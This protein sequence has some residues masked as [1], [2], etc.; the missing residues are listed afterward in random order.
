MKKICCLV[1]FLSFLLSCQEELFIHDKAADVYTRSAGDGRFD[2]LGYGYDITGTYLSAESSKAQVL[3]IEKLDQD[4]LITPYKLETSDFRYVSGSDAYE[5]VS[6]MTSSI[7]M[8]GL[9]SSTVIGGTS[10]NVA[11]GGNYHFNSDFAYAYYS[12]KYVDSRY[13]ISEVDVETLKQYLSA[14]FKRHI[15][16]YT[17][18]QIVETYGT[19]VLKDVYLG[20]KLEVYY[21]ST[22]EKLN[23]KNTV[24]A[25]C[26]ASLLKLFNITADFHYDSSLTQ[27]NKQQS[28]YYT[29]IGGDP[30]QSLVGVINPETSSA[31]DISKW[32]S[33]IKNSTPKFIDVDRNSNSFIPIYELISDS[34]KKNEVKNYITNYINSKEI[35]VEKLYPTTSGMNEIG[36]LGYDSAGAGVCMWDIDKNGKPDLIYMVVDASEG[37]NTFWY[38]VLYDID[39]Y[40][41]YQRKSETYKVSAGF[42][43]TTDGGIAIGD[44]DKN[45]KPDLIVMASDKPNSLQDAFFNYRILYDL[46][47]NGEYTR[48]S[49]IKKFDAM[50]FFYS[51]SDIALYDVNQNNTLDL[52]FMAYD[53]PDGDNSFRYQIA[54]DIDSKGDY[55][56]TSSCYS[57]EGMGTEAEGAGISLGDIGNDGN[58]DMLL[59]V[60][61]SPLNKSR[62]FRYKV[63]PNI[64]KGGASFSD[65]TLM[66]EIP[67]SPCEIGAGAGCCLYDIDGDTRLDA[68]FVAV[69]SVFQENTL[70]YFMGFN[71]TTYGVP[72]YWR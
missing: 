9:F 70:K 28:L 33:G 55:K 23:K 39:E 44:I 60:L 18:R 63:L 64:D 69:N 47:T 45:G 17:P 26:G 25:G 27:S 49:E 1:C 16:I 41:Y 57:I 72:S 36:G 5:F 37:G 30:S 42:W 52:V 8:N 65:A 7:K 35:H 54:F 3:D 40:G 11:F 13:V 19:H 53:N 14:N 22:S 48:M 31:I 71:W 34:N 6:N 59:M 68:I 24:D 29:T 62:R 20:A 21:T 46:S 61:D 58:I 50:G 15:E 10:L 56:Y 12:D 66:Q 51:G 43:E 2:I 4:R 38:N 67:I 32:R